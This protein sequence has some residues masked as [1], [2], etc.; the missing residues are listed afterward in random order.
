MN[1]FL[2]PALFGT[3][4]QTQFRCSQDQDP[5]RRFQENQLSENDEQWHRLVPEEA[6]A[7][8]PEKEVKR[9]AVIFE[10]I[11]SEKEYVA[12]L[13]A[14]QDVSS[15]FSRVH[16]PLITLGGIDR[17]SSPHSSTSACRLSISKSRLSSAMKS[18]P[19]STG[20]WRMNIAFL[21]HCMSDSGSSTLS[22]HLLRTLSSMLSL[23]SGRTTNPISRWAIHLIL[24][25][26]E[27]SKHQW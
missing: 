23:P 12:D 18:F 1:K 22:L 25:P 5:I 7:S 24:K 4:V 16:R 14:L 19:I 10:I 8:L 21:L 15:I 26:G 17:F 6:R 3:H 2:S 9:Q 11:K 13:E 20:S 27:D